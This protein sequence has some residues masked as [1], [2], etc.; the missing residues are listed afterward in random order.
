MRQS[1]P[2]LTTSMTWTAAAIEN[3]PKESGPHDVPV[4]RSSD[5]PTNFTTRFSLGLV[6]TL[7]VGPVG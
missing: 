3:V 1:R 6:V 5:E 4:S 2:V 7:P